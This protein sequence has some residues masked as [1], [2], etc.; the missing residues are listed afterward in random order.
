MMLPANEKK[1]YG[2]VKGYAKSLYEEGA[3]QVLPQ[4]NYLGTLDTGD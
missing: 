4:L 2:D 3:A 1:Q